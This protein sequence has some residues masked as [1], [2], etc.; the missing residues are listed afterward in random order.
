[1]KAN[2]K[3]RHGETTAVALLMCKLATVGGDCWA[4]T[5]LGQVQKPGWA[6][7]KAGHRKAWWLRG[8]W[9]Q[10]SVGV[11]KALLVQVN[12]DTSSGEANGQPG[13]HA[14]IPL[15][16]PNVHLPS[17]SWG[18][19]QRLSPAPLPGLLLLVSPLCPQ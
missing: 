6:S 13:Q 4:R 2:Q 9:H 8:R 19:A 3:E 16:Y 15:C 11:R 12:E 17:S 18:G 5:W 14:S 7:A 1:M 10:W